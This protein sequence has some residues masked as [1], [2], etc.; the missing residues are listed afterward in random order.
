MGRCVLR[1]KGVLQDKWPI[2][3]VA[4]CRIYPIRRV[5]PTSRGCLTGQVA[6]RP[7]DILPSVPYKAN[8][9]YRPKVF[10]GTSGLQVEWHTIECEIYLKTM[11]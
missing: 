10:Y 3:R 7:S 9:A 2:G 5:W 8:V 6:Y 11:M 1:A 4:Y